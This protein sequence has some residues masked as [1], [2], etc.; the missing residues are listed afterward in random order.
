M[1]ARW[2]CQSKKKKKKKKKKTRMKEKGANILI[3]CTC[4][5]GKEIRSDVFILGKPCVSTTKKYI[6][7]NPLSWRCSKSNGY[8]HRNGCAP[9]FLKQRGDSAFNAL[10]IPLCWLCPRM[11]LLFLLSY[12]PNPSA[13]I[14]Y[15]TRSI[16]KRSL[17]VFNSEFS[18]S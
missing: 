17:T 4:A 1:A 14:G 7:Y 16:F 8:R 10:T 15:D 18:F 11:T 13:R 12:L 3:S 2:H 9:T 6:T 5:S